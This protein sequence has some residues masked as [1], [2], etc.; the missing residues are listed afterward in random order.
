MEWRPAPAGAPKA[1][2]RETRVLVDESLQGVEVAG[3]DRRNDRR[4]RP[5]A[6]VIGVPSFFCGAHAQVVPSTWRHPTGKTTAPDVCTNNR[7]HTRI[8]T[9]VRPSPLRPG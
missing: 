8:G 6:I 2:G 5:Q 9:S 3:A 1:G 4:W 7:A